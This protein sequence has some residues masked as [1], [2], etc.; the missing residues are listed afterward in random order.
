MIPV[1][2]ELQLGDVASDP[3]SIPI[4]RE[5]LASVKLLDVLVGLTGNDER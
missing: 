2:T 5:A 3:V 4:E 1:T